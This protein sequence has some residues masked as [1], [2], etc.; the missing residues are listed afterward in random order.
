MC[1]SYTTNIVHCV[2]LWSYSNHWRFHV[3]GTGKA[4]N[5]RQV[6]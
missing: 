6:Q 2:R 5:V 1:S 4:V 3:K